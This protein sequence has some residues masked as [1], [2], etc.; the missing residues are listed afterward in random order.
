MKASFSERNDMGTGNVKYSVRVNKSIRLFMIIN[1]LKDKDKIN[2]KELAKMLSVSERTVYRDIK[3]LRNIGVPIYSKE[4]KL[5][6]DAEMW[7]S[8]SAKHFLK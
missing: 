7:D 6:L 4:N 2:T 3:D 5:M 1:I 8:W